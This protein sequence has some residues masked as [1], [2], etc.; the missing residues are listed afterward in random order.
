MNQVPSSKRSVS[1]GVARLIPKELQEILWTLH[2]EHP[3]L[4]SIFELKSR[5]RYTQHIN[6]LCLLPYYDQ[7][8]TVKIAQPINDIR[9]TI[10]QTDNSLLMRL[11]NKQ[12]EADLSPSQIGPEQ[13]ELF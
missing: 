11:S 2:Q 3:L 9:V 1:P 6:H 10:L 12:L 7:H 8:H 4:P 13:G 5:G